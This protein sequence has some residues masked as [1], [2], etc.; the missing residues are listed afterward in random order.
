[1][2]KEKDWLYPQQMIEAVKKVTDS[3]IVVFSPIN[4]L[5]L[6]NISEK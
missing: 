3:I 2:G 5:N 4:L 1:M 6:Q